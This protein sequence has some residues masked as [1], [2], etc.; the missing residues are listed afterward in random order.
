MILRTILIKT[1]RKLPKRMKRTTAIRVAMDYFAY[2]H[3]I[4]IAKT[5]GQQ[6]ENEDDR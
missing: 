5:W 2:P 3:K 4:I 1:N 6:F